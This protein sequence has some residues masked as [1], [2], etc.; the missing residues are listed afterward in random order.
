MR[1]VLVKQVGADGGVGAHEGAAVAL[2][3]RFGVPRGRLH[4]DAALL[5]GGQAHVD[6][7]VLVT[8]EGADG[9]VVA[10]LR[11]DG[12]Q[13]V[14]DHCG[15]ISLG[16]ALVERG[17]GPAGGHGD[18]H[19]LLCA[20]LDGRHVLGHHGVA[21][22]RVGLAGRVLHVVER[23][24]DGHQAR[25]LEERR[26][27][28]GVDVA[29]QAHALRNLHRVHG[30]Q[31]D[32]VLRDVALHLAGQVGIKLFGRPAGVEQEGTPGLHFLHHVVLAHVALVV[33]G[34][35]VR[36]L[37][38]VGAADGL[39]R[40][41]QVGLGHAEGL[42]GVVLEVCLRVHVGA[43]AQDADGVVVRAHGAVAAQAP[44]L[45]AV[46]VA[47]LEVVERAHGKRQV[48]HVVGDADGEAAL[49]LGCGKVVEHGHDLGGV[50]VLGRQAVAAADDRHLAGAV[51]VGDDAG[52]VQEQRLARR[53][54]AFAAVEHRDALHGFRQ[55]AQ[56][57]LRRERAVQVH[58]QKAVAL[59][60]AVGLRAGVQVVA[61]LLRGSRHAA[62][63]HHD[64]GGVGGAVVVEH[65]MFAAG[66]AGH[67][68]HNALDHVGQLVV[69]GV[70]RLTL[71]EVRVAVLH[72]GAQHGVLGV[73]SA[74]TEAVERLGVHERGQL[75]GVGHVDAR[76]LMGGAEAVEE[77]HE[78][79]G[80][81]HGGK[82]GDGGHVG[83][84]LDA[85]RA[86][87]GEPGVAARH[88]VGVVAEDA[89]GVGAHG[90]ACHVQHAWQALAGDAIEHGHH[91]H[92]ALAGREA[93]AQAACLQHAV[94]GGDGA[95]LGL[96]LGQLHALAEHVQTALRAPAIGVLGHGRGRRDGVDGRHLGEVVGNV[97]RSLVAI[98]GYIVAH[99]EAPLRNDGLKTRAGAR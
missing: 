94:D 38:V 19:A 72:G 65:V 10:L 61:R 33:A 39:L 47:V 76:Q 35:E 95:C 79:D 78:G 17:V 64:I 9:Q 83:G 97:G 92:Q 1:L 51:A 24:L 11:V 44:K 80:C 56:E 98:D 81:L 14:L 42:L 87:L 7:A 50:G 82:V 53:A 29:A 86:E 60:R 52:N 30:E 93:G 85:S 23:L 88:D 36:A 54:H 8:G 77:M 75:L 59:A 20:L 37:H 13:D 22:A 74:R 16:C 90:A 21:L 66:H 2:D 31:A 34:H 43:V 70:V 18:F 57:V 45:A 15:H 12:A 84:L 49:G 89:H 28:Y 32:A 55:G 48:R 26:L 69:C 3:A 41:A 46:G 96:H 71:L 27:Q 63:G 58:L 62:H 91:E 67:L 40:K 25:D 5:V 4:G 68:R 99:C 73:Q 6:D